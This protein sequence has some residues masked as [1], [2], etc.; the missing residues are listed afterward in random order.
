MRTTLTLDDDVSAALESVRKAGDLKLRRLINDVLRRGLERMRARPA[1]AKRFRTRS[2][3][4][5]N[6]RL[7]D[8]DNVAEALSHAEGEGRP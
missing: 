3:A 6:C 2:A 4:L 5:G 7:G 1:P 8:V